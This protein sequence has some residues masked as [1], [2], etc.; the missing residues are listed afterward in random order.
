MMDRYVYIYIYTYIYTYMHSYI[1]T[2]IHAHV[3][4][5]EGAVFA[6][7]MTKTKTGARP[8]FWKVGIT[9]IVRRKLIIQLTLEN[10]CQA[11]VTKTEWEKKALLFANKMSSAAHIHVMRKVYLYMYTYINIYIYIYIYTCI[12]I[13]TYIHPCPH[14]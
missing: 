9:V 4:M 13:H 5:Y 7:H 14:T 11:R 3:Y 10:C 8:K 2:Y 12:F 1:H 6:R